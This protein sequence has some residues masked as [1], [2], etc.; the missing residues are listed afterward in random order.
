MKKCITNNN[1]RNKIQLLHDNYDLISELID[2]YS[3][4]PDIKSKYKFKNYDN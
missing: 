1:E 4:Y 2:I 3:K